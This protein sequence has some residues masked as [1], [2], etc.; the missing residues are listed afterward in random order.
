MNRW[1]MKM[2]SGPRRKQSELAKL[3]DLM[4]HREVAYYDALSGETDN[5]DTIRRR[6]DKF[7]EAKD[8]Y[9]RAVKRRKSAAR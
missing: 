7:K 6:A 5:P 9:H 3:R 1:D 4:T 2:G 8:A